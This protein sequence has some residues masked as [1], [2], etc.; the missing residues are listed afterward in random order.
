[1]APDKPPEFPIRALVDAAGISWRSPRTELAARYGVRPHPAY[2]WDVI[3]IETAQAFFPPL[4]WPVSVQVFPNFAP[5]M[6]ATEFS[7]HVYLTPD[8]RAN[9]SAAEK[10]L[11][12]LLGKEGSH[13]A[14]SNALRRSWTFGAARAEL[15]VWPPELQRW[16][17]TNRAHEREPRLKTACYLGINTGYRTVCSAHELAMFRTFEPISPIGSKESPRTN[18][19]DSPAHQSELEFVREPH[20]E[21][22]NLIGLLGRSA[23]G[24]TLIFFGSQLYLVPMKDVIGFRVARVRPAKGPGGSH[25]WIECRTSHE[26]VA[27]KSLLI[28]SAGGVEELNGLAA[29]ISKATGTPFELGDY[30]YDA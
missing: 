4:L 15:I 26:A 14:S 1:M 20:P 16:H 27:T 8:A 30:E 17:M 22:M 9:L 2:G 18:V 19:R 6:P 25:L 21:A 5:Q 11:T 3:E 13:N 28:T 7:G 29:T 10:R 24:A 23:D 12:E